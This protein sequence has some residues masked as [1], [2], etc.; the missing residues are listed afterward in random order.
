MD[1]FAY[2][3]TRSH[4]FWQPGADPGNNETKG[5]LA[6]MRAKILKKGPLS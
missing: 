5:I 6:K 1:M 4:I 3:P 2:C